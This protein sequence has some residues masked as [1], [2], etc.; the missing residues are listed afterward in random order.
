MDGSTPFAN[1]G[2][3]DIARQDALE[4]D[5]TRYTLTVEAA[6]ALFSKADV[7]RSKRTVQRYCE[8]GHLDCLKVETMR[9][10]KY[11]VSEESVQNRIKEL[12]Q[13]VA[14]GQSETMHDMSSHDASLHDT[15]RSDAPERVTT[16]HDAITDVEHVQLQQK[17]DELEEENTRLRADNSHLEITNKFKDMYITHVTRT[18]AEKDKR[19]G[20]FERVIG[21]LETILRLKAPNEETA[22][23]IAYIDAPDA[24]TEEVRPSEGH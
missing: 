2:E 18:L 3:Q 19:I 14:T 11:L 8:L 13:L 12:Q 10:E 20:R 21:K 15:A 17:I 6:S 23:I 22:S 5:V 9:S 7:P 4:R 24:T 1:T 16:R